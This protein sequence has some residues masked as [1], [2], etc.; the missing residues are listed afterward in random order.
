MKVSQ[1]VVLTD[2][3]DVFL[4]LSKRVS[5][6]TF[7][8]SLFVIKEFAGTIWTNGKLDYEKNQSHIL[9]ISVT[10]SNCKRL[11]FFK[12]FTSIQVFS[13]FQIDIYLLF[14]TLSCFNCRGFELV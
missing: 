5:Q 9:N 1:L 13:S 3:L 8:D 6:F 4:L 10:V 11:K 12:S 2:P 7:Q 14:I